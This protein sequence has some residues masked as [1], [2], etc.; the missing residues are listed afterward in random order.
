MRIEFIFSAHLS[1]VLGLGSI[2][3]FDQH[4]RFYNTLAQCQC[5]S[6]VR[7]SAL[8]YIFCI[9]SDGSI[10]NLRSLMARIS[11]D[12]AICFSS[13]KLFTVNVFTLCLRPGFGIY[14][15][16]ITWQDPSF[17]MASALGAEMVSICIEFIFQRGFEFLDVALVPLDPLILAEPMPILQLKQ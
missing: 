14:F 7:F 16:T 15:L 11:E 12:P 3:L 1:P 9:S 10:I 4:S 2:L 17:R 5:S 13:R 8:D 6:R